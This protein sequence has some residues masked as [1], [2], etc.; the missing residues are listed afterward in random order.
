MNA[1]P[2]QRVEVDRQRGHQGLAFAGAHLG[3]LAVV[4]RHATDVLHI[5]VPHLQAA[6]AALAHRS[7]GLGHQIV[8]R[9]TLGNALAEFFGLGPQ[10][11]VV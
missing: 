9:R 7:E 5:E 11:V 4:Q 2:R 10:R 8:Q 3:D 6:L 1:L